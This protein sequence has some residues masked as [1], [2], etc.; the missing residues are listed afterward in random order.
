ML[1]VKRQDCKFDFEVR[2]QRHEECDRLGLDVVFP[3]SKW[4]LVKDVKP[5]GLVA[6]WNKANEANVHV[7][8]SDYILAVNGVSGD[9]DKMVA[10][11]ADKMVSLCVLRHPE[12]APLPLGRACRYDFDVCL[13]RAAPEEKI[14]LDLAFATDSSCLL[15]RGI[16]ESGLANSWNRKMA[17]RELVCSDSI[18]AVNGVTGDLNKMVLRLQEMTV[19]LCIRRHV[20]GTQLPAARRAQVRKKTSPSLSRE[21]EASPTTSRDSFGE[22]L[23]LRKFAL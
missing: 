6:D 12:Q 11:L 20:K 8:L 2:L 3:E 18:V 14:G 21:E 1:L 13:H 23:P 15:I 5:Q 9:A 10:R 7:R 16:S 17:A 4:L 22:A 19:H